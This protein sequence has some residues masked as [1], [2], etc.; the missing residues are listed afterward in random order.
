MI[1]SS[2]FGV[3]LP[4]GTYAPGDVVQLKLKDGPGVVRSGRG[5]AI[6]K[7]TIGGFLSEASGALTFWKIHIRNSDWIDDAQMLTTSL[8]DATTLDQHSGA[9]RIGNDTN[10]TPNSSWEVWAECIIGGTTTAANSLFALIDIDYPQVSSIVDPDALI[11]IPAS[12][13]Y[14]ITGGTINAPNIEAAG[15]QTVNLDILKAGY[16]YALQE[17]AAFTAAGGGPRGFVKIS[18]A[19]GMGGLARIV[20]VSCAPA[21]IKQTIQYAS[22]LVKGPMDLSVMLFNTS[23]S[24]SDTIILM[25]FVKRRM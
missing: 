23:A 14:K 15:W 9:V 11:G 2:L 6:L 5:S 16:Q 8:G 3:S 7:R 21:A 19:A 12:L 13:D 1:D 18:N 25:D 24:T 10:L 22:L 4:T 17:I 20:P